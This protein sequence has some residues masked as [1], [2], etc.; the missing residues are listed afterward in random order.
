MMMKGQDRRLRFKL[1]APWFTYRQRRGR[2]T[3]RGDTGS[4]R[5][6]RR[7]RKTYHNCSCSSGYHRRLQATR[8]H[9]CRLLHSRRQLRLLQTQLSE[10]R[11]I[12]SWVLRKMLLSVSSFLPAPVWT[13]TTTFRWSRM[14]VRLII[15]PQKHRC[16]NDFYI[17]LHGSFMRADFFYFV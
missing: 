3:Q 12:S 4:D 14:R 10:A 17:S 16:T 8:L 6:W 15:T 1:S 2:K 9:S 7:E 13:F 11:P 5:R